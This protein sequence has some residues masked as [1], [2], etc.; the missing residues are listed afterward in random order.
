MMLTHLIVRP[1][2]GSS[3]SGALTKQELDD[4]VKFGTKELFKDEDSESKIKVLS[5]NILLVTIVM[6]K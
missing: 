3:H 6:Y 5:E 4:I 1:G 2:L